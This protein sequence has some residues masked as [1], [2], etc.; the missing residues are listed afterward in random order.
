MRF[1]LNIFSL[2]FLWWMILL[3]SACT[4]K[5]TFNTLPTIEYNS[6]VPTDN[7]LARIILNFEDGDGDL[8]Q[9]VGSTTP[10]FFLEFEYKDTDGSFKPYYDA[11]AVPRPPLPDTIIYQK[12]IFAY[13][14]VQPKELQ[15]NQYIKG[16]IIITMSGWRPNNTFKVFRYRVKAYDRKGNE[17]NELITSAISVGF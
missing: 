3:L 9:P 17:S 8:F 4:K 7:Q 12:K 13:T 10:N 16:N 6:F 11:I 2:S 14:I 15:S 1:H 5:N